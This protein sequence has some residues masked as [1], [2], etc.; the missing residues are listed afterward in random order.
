MNDNIN[1]N[2]IVWGQTLFFCHKNSLSSIFNNNSAYAFEFVLKFLWLVLFIS[3]IQLVL[4]ILFSVVGCEEVTRLRDFVRR[5]GCGL[6]NLSITVMARRPLWSPL[7]FL[8]SHF[9]ESSRW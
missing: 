7:P 4:R 9:L 2:V 8:T 1:F 5:R 3:G 6:G